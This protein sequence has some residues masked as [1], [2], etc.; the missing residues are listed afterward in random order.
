V[1]SAI[2]VISM[3]LGLFFLGQGGGSLVLALIAMCAG[4]YCIRKANLPGLARAERGAGNET[5][6]S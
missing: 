4:L 5:Q 3:L 1:W 6:S 2:G